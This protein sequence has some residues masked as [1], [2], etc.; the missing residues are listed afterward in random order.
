MHLVLHCLQAAQ[1]LFIVL[2]GFSKGLGHEEGEEI[3]RDIW[4][5]CRRWVKGSR[6]CA[7]AVLPPCSCLS[8]QL[9]PMA[10]RWYCSCLVPRHV[11]YSWLPFRDN[12]GEAQEAAFYEEPLHE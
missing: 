4:L 6:E 7:Y 9:T 3:Y 12:D 5:R 10:L 8:S 1:A 2:L 11:A